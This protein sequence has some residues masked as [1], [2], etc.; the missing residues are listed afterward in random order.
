MVDKDSEDGI[1]SAT[2]KAFSEEDMNQRMLIDRLLNSLTRL[3]HMHFSLSP[4]VP[5]VTDSEARLLVGIYFHKDVTSE[6]RPGMLSKMAHFKPA[7]LSQHLTSLMKKGYINRVISE[8]D[9]RAVNIVITS[10]GCAVAEHVHNLMMQQVGDLI[11]Y[12]G[13]DDIQTLISILD[14]LQAYQAK[15]IDEGK[16]VSMKHDGGATC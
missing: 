16:L 2:P 4:Q 13:A 6:I 10:E 12:M 7:A 8:Q 5:E 14:R 1:G 3:R 11:E 15:L 9:S